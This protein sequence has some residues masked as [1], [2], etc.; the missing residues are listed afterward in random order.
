MEDV[1]GRWLVDQKTTFLILVQLQ[2]GPWGQK[3]EIIRD[4]QEPE[5]GIGQGL[6]SVSLE[7]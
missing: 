6:R 3:N 2:K 5:D 7:P 4:Q 1:Y